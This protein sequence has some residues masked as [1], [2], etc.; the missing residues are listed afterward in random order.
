MIVN[1]LIDAD[2]VVIL[3]VIL[4]ETLQGIKADKI[5]DVTKE[6]LLSYHYFSI[7]LFIQQSGR[8]NCNKKAK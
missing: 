7:G 3:P 4:Q 1:K 5:F 8:L 2:E 6:L